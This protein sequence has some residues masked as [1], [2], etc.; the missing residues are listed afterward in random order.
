[1]REK[2]VRKIR[3]NRGEVG[4]VRGD[5]G[6]INEKEWGGN[7][8]TARRESRVNGKRISRTIEEK[9]VIEKWVK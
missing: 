5:E 8:E 2:K 4:K 9:F 1:M 6:E 3:G 7:L